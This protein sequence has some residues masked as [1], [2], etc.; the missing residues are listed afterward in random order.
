[1]QRAMQTS[2]ESTHFVDA[3]GSVTQLVI[4][5][6]MS[7]Q[8]PRLFGMKI[9]ILAGTLFVEISVSFCYSSLGAWMPTHH[10]RLSRSSCQPPF[11][12]ICPSSS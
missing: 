9:Y 1:M 11:R 10:R 2:E 12:P 4:H 5:S 3:A 6:E 8:T 7:A